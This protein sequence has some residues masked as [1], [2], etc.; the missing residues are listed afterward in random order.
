M[1]STERLH[2]SIASF[3]LNSTVSVL[4]T[5]GTLIPVLQLQYITCLLHTLHR[6]FLY[7]PNSAFVANA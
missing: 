7:G 1:I 3:I 6:S 4:L 2:A 5:V